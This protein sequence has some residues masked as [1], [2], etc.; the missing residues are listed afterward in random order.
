[1]VIGILT[2][3]LEIPGSNSLKDK[4]QAVKSLL[5]TIRLKYNVSASEL[6]QLDSWRRSTIGVACISN[7][8]VFANQVLNSVMNRIESDARVVALDF[9]L[10]FV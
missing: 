4:R 10:E 2:I 6:D 9:S 1:M 5:D 3:S 8:K 7:D